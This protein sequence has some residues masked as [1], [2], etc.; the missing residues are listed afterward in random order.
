MYI[1]IGRRYSSPRVMDQRSITWTK[2]SN[3]PTKPGVPPRALT[4]ASPRAPPT[5][6][7]GPAPLS[8]PY[9]SRLP[10]RGS[11]LLARRSTRRRTTGGSKPPCHPIWRSKE[12]TGS[13]AHRRWSTRGR[14]TT[15]G[16]KPPH[17][18]ICR[19]KGST[20]SR[21]R[22][23][24]RQRG[25]IGRSRGSKEGAVARSLGGG[26]GRRAQ[27]ELRSPPH[28]FPG[29]STMPPKYRFESGAWNM[30]AHF[31]GTTAGRNRSSVL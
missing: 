28:C 27:M 20:R 29:C 4:L 7:T 22:S 9:T 26:D 30:E 6:P 21:A 18:R 13:R 8:W 12:S 25:I 15:G 31:Q 23:R 17:R 11:N 19:R 1:Y 3:W 5:R 14:R 24:C 2:R 16:S 10:A